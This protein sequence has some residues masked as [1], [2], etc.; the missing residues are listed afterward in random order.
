MKPS[1]TFPNRQVVVVL[2]GLLFCPQAGAMVITEN[3]SLKLDSSQISKGIF[4]DE[5]N[6]GTIKTEAEPVLLARGDSYTANIT[7]E[8]M[9]HI[10]LNDGFFNG[11][12]SF[13]IEI[14]GLV[15]G[16]NNS[17]GPADY[18][19]QFTGVHHG[20]LLK[21]PL[22]GSSTLG[23]ATG[24]MRLAEDVD[25]I[26]GGK[27]Q[28]HDLHLTVTNQGFNAWA[29]DGFRLGVGADVV[30]IG[31]W[32]VPAPGSA[33]LLLAGLLPLLTRRRSG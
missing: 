8:G 6:S 3:F 2:L 1:N 19:L 22:S 24:N 13:L 7:F 21:N 12:E 25:L 16:A 10:E 9:Q 14:D 15:G 31:D 32:K 11:D 26:D 23:L 33:A 29:F 20:P 17:D 28:F 4:D 5:W 27:V 30:S 18:L